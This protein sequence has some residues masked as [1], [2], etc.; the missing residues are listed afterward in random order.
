[1]LMRQWLAENH[2]IHLPAWLDGIDPATAIPDPFADPVGH[3]A[4]VRRLLDGFLRSRTVFYPGSGSDGDPV[5]LFNSARAAACF[6][7]VDYLLARHRL[8]DE[9][10][11]NGFRG[12]SRVLQVDLEAGDFPPWRP[13]VQPL[14][15]ARRPLDVSP[16]GMLC[17]F[18]RASRPEED[19]GQ[20]RF[21]ILF[22]CADGHAAYD[23]LYCQGNGVPAPFCFVAEDHG[24]GG[25][26]SPWGMGGVAHQVAI[27]RQ[28]FPRLMLV[29]EGSTTPWPDYD[30]VPM[31]GDLQ[32]QWRN[33][34]TMW[35][36]Q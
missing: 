7:Y 27:T 1:M 34:R 35:E 3:R 17:I 26:Y 9:I 5:A 8:L 36:R 28:V 22:L 31:P 2:S 23:G 33:L 11:R 25:N 30:R 10:E 19:L 18:E 15:D 14:P 16:Y 4:A 24:F 32:G 21:A 13:S 20:R 12:Y 6:V 29:A